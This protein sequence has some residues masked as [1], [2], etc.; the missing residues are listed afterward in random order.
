MAMLAAVIG[1]AVLTAFAAWSPP[2]IRKLLLFSVAYGLCVG[3]IVNRAAKDSGIRRLIAVGLTL[4][5]T[6][7]GLMVIAVRGHRQFEAEK[8]AAVKAAPDQAMARSIIEAA[9]VH[10]P[11]LAAQLA[12]EAETRE[13]SFGDYL[14]LRVRPLGEWSQPW[15]VVFWG[16]EVLLAAACSGFLVSRQLRSPT[17]ST[18]EQT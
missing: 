10:D 17:I 2:S 14:A 18:E 3:A 13:L 16:A 9:A 4:G 5:L 11:Q 12:E 6:V 7:T 8:T 15:P 1:V